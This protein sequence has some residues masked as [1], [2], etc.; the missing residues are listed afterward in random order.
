MKSELHA[1][2]YGFDVAL[3]V[4][5]GFPDK[6]LVVADDHADEA[7]VAEHVATLRVRVSQATVGELAEAAVFAFC[8]DRETKERR[9]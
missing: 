3:T 2:I 6:K 9:V 4:L 5:T 8:T 7:L 1:E